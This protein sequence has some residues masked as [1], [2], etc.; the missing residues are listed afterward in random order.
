MLG[1]RS[2]GRAALFEA[3]RLNPRDPSAGLFPGW[4]T[5]SYYYDSNYARAVTM[6]NTVIERYPHFTNIYGRLAAALAQLGRYDEAR[7]ALE[8]ATASKSF[9][10]HVRA[11]QH[12]SGPRTTSTCCAACERQVGRAERGG[13]VATSDM[14]LP[15]LPTV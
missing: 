10:F 13:W 3:V 5:M 14:N 12:G 9:E 1:D 8:H 6:A 15:D 7:E 2:E 11:G 4:I